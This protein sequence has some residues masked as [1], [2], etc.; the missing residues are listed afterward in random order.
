VG[1]LG[2]AVWGGAAKLL[3]SMGSGTVPAENFL[4]HVGA[5]MCVW[6]FCSNNNV[7][8]DKKPCATLACY[9][10]CPVQKQILCDLWATC[11]K[12]VQLAAAALA[13]IAKYFAHGRS[14]KYCDECV[15]VSVCLVC[16]LPYL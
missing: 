2:W 1:V 5:L 9:D 12:L 10:K 11:I 6:I 7:Q 15:C 16:P 4:Q 13:E 3:S 8:V 14:A